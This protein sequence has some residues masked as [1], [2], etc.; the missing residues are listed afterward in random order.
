MPDRFDDTIDSVGGSMVEHASI[1][2]PEALAGYKSALE[3]L[4]IEIHTRAMTIEQVTKLL[5]K[6]NGL[7]P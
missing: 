3:T 7:L 6:V 1:L 4:A 2:T 5:D